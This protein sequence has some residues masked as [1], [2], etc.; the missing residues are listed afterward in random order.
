VGTNN[1]DSLFDFWKKSVWECR[2]GATIDHFAIA[3]AV[4]RKP[5]EDEEKEN[6]TVGDK[7]DRYSRLTELDVIYTVGKDYKQQEEKDKTGVDIN[8]DYEKKMR[9]KYE[10]EENKML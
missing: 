7:Y 6:E 1:P 4:T 9:Q 10:K 3:K 5:E 2:K 8:E